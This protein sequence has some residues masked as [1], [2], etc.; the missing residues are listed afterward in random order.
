MAIVKLQAP[1]TGLRGKYGGMIFSENGSSPYVRQWLMPTA[2]RTIPQASKRSWM[3][4]IRHAWGTLAQAD[5]DDWD[6]LA[7]APPEIDVNPLKVTY[8]LSGSAWHTRINLRRLQAGQAIEN[9]APVNLAVDPPVTFTLTAYETA[10][11]GRTDEFGYTQD[12][13]DGFYA[14][15][16]ISPIQS[17]VRQVQKANYLSIWC[18]TV[19]DSTSQEI[20]P[21]L[22]AAFGVLTT[23]HKLFGRLWKQSD[24]GIRSVPLEAT[25]IVL[26]E[27]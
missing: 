5:I 3:A 10:W 8:L 22:E 2:K 23:G 25:C 9:D 4:T 11:A 20:T 13:F 19:D 24:T 15:L 21:E 18:G 17:L 1:I 14:A 7:L 27:P 6:A 16:H 26:P 12:D